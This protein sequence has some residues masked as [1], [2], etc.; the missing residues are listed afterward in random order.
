MSIDTWEID[1]IAGSPMYPAANPVIPD[2]YADRMAAMQR[3]LEGIF[4][5]A[6]SGI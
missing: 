1:K 3:L 5:A 4:A 6:R 2:F